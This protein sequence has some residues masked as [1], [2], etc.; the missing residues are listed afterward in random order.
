MLPPKLERFAD[1]ALH[2]ICPHCHQSLHLQERS[3]VCENRHSFDLAKQGYVNLAPQA[4][5]SQHY[6]KESFLARQAIL[7]AGLYD[8]I[9]EGLA[10]RI[11]KLQPQSILDVACGEGFYS[12]QLE[13]RYSGNYYAFDLAKDSILLASKADSRQHIKWFVADLAKIPLES[14]SLDLILDIFSP[15][16]YQEFERLLQPQGT[17]LKVIPGSQHLIEIRKI[18]G[19]EAYQPEDIDLHLKEQMQILD[20]EELTATYPL[21][22][23]LREALLEMTPL[24]Q[25]VNLTD[26]DWTKLTHITISAT[27]YQ[28]RF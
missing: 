14:H 4:K 22:P 7:E 5:A 24:L 1:P 16:N 18:L 20:Q 19:K 9:L 15:A 25:Q 8:P 12:R 10:Q 2:F 27:L 21:T 28:A 17:V 6:Q 23:P 11:G 13:S 26:F 3:L